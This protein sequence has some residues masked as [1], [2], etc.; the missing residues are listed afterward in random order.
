[1]DKLVRLALHAWLEVSS[2]LLGGAE[3]LTLNCNC[4]FHPTSYGGAL[5]HSKNHPCRSVLRSATIPNGRELIYFPTLPGEFGA[6][7]DSSRTIYLIGLCRLHVTR[8]SHVCLAALQQG[9]NFYQLSAQKFRRGKFTFNC[10][11]NWVRA[12]PLRLLFRGQK[13]EKNVFVTGVIN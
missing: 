4:L 13:G 8:V 12:S 5:N 1:M 2:V 3:S 6:V 11:E 9:N 7:L 10:C